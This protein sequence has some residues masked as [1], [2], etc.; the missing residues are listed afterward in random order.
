MELVD[1]KALEEREDQFL[2]PY[3]MRSAQS[4]GRRHL[5]P[6]TPTAR[7]T[8]A[9]ATASSTAPLSGGWSTRRR[10]S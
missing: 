8:S 9:T 5:E 1:R 6:T 3:G 7:A 4:R 10:S 2:A